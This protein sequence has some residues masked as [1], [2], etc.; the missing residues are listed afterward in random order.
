MAIYANL[1]NDN[2]WFA[3]SKDEN[4]SINI[5]L[6]DQPSSIKLKAALINSIRVAIGER[7]FFPK[8]VW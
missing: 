8:V 5:D 3:A 4:K 6:I 2:S 7:T 1:D